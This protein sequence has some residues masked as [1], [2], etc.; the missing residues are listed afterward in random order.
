MKRILL[1]IGVIIITT[2]FASAELKIGV[3]KVDQI[4]KEAP[5]T[6]ISNRSRRWQVH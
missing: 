2:N 5:Q 4:I 3:V 1:A 6:D